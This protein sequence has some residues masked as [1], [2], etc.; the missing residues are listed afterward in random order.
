MGI[1]EFYLSAVERAFWESVNLGQALVFIAVAAVGLLG[2]RLR[3]PKGA[4]SHV[5]AAR[6]ALVLLIALVCARLPFAIYGL[7]DEEHT[8]RIHA[9]CVAAKLRDSQ[10]Q[11]RQFISQNLQG[12][13]VRAQTLMHQAIT[14]EQFPAWGNEEG[15]LA[16]EMQEWIKTNMGPGAAARVADMNGP[17]YDFSGMP[18]VN[19]THV[20]ALNWLNKV[21]ANLAV[22]QNDPQWD[23]FKPPEPPDC[24]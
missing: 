4:L 11:R 12:F 15:R 24:A 20:S 8:K 14:A 9:E 7:W 21:S 16:H 18:I 23:S 1:A 6:T 19:A 5:T 3:D 13:Y 2:N 10:Q 22:L 17:T